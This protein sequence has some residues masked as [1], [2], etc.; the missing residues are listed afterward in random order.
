MSQSDKKV[1][2]FGEKSCR[3]YA[4]LMRC[5]HEVALNRVDDVSLTDATHPT[6]H[7]SFA[8]QNPPSP[9]GEGFLFFINHGILRLCNTRK[10]RPL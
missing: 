10:Y 5:S 3:S 2:V 4:R 6:P 8:T 7:P 9:Q 1:P